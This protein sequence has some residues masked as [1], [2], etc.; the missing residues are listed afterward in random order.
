VANN[1]NANYGGSSIAS[2]DSFYLLNGKIAWEFVLKS[3]PLSGEIYL[4]GEN[5]TNTSYAYR[6]DYPMPGTNGTIGA[7]LKF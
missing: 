6:K 7:S 1:R 3:P 4:A 2:V 5:L